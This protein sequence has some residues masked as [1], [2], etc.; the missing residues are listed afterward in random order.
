MFVCFTTVTWVLPAFGSWAKAR[1]CWFMSL[2][3][4]LIVLVFVYE[5]FNVD[6]HE[7]FTVQ[8]PCAVN[9]YIG[10]LTSTVYPPVI[11]ILSL[12][13][14]LLIIEGIRH[15]GELIQ[16]AQELIMCR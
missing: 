3:S 1:I 15:K 16:W 13:I 6:I 9:Q 5:W 11:Y 4:G 2:M 12:I 14:S 7:Y 8:A 10:T